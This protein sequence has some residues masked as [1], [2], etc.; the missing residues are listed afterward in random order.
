MPKDARHDMIAVREVVES[1]RV[2]K[3][4]VHDVPEELDVVE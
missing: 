2:E 1:S 3:G 4:G